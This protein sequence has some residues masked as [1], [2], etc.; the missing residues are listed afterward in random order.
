VKVVLS[1]ALVCR[2]QS[3]QIGCIFVT[4]NSVNSVNILSFFPPVSVLCVS[5]HGASSFSNNNAL[6]SLCQFVICVVNFWYFRARYFGVILVFFGDSCS[7]FTLWNTDAKFLPF[8]R[9][10]FFSFVGRYFL[11]AIFDGD[12]SVSNSILCGLLTAA[13][14]SCS[15]DFWILILGL[16]AFFVDL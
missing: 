3:P 11:L 13:D 16:I 9:R 14:T 4:V 15:L 8:C 5:L 10:A 7:E 12:D 2:Y 6:F 1:L